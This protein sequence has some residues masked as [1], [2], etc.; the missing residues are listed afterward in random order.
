MVLAPLAVTSERADVIDFLTPYLG[1]SGL[2]ILRKHS[3]AKDFLFLDVFSTTVWISC[4]AVIMITSIILYIYQQFES[5][6]D[7]QNN[8]L[9]PSFGDATWFVVSSICFEGEM[10]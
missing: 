4:L 3:I 7:N 10:T 8:L 5:L 6:V 1:T 9:R 2:Q